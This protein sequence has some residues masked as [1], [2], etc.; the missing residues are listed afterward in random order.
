[1]DRD[2]IVYKSHQYNRATDFQRYFLDTHDAG[3]PVFIGEFGYVP[4]VGMEMADV[5]ALMDVARDRRLSWAAWKFDHE[6]GP[7]LVADNTT[8]APSVP[9]GAAVHEELSADAPVP[10]AQ[11]A[12][13]PGARRRP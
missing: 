1:V 10:P 6:G 2:N 3:K 8:F 4:E 5:Q 12:P 7:N 9:Y 11:A 13:A